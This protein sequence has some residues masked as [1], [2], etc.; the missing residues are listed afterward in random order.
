MENYFKQI[1]KCLVEVLNVY[2]TTL[3]RLNSFPYFTP[4]V[5][6]SKINLRI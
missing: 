6:A 4:R 2:L 1:Q 5:F 3:P